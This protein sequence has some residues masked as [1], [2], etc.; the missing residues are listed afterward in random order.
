ME[1][2]Q[3]SKRKIA[4]LIVSRA[5]EGRFRAW[6]I[7]QTHFVGVYPTSPFIHMLKEA[8]ITFLFVGTLGFSLCSI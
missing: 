4:F 8:I 5:D 2:N 6:H 3:V 7:V 1:K